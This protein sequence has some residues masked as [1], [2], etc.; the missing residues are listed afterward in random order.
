[1]ASHARI[2]YAPSLTS[3]ETRN[4]CCPGTC[5]QQLA[6]PLRSL[7]ISP[8]LG[9]GLPSAIGGLRILFLGEGNGQEVF[10][11][12]QAAGAAGEVFAVTPQQAR[13]DQWR[14]WQNEFSRSQGFDN[15]SLLYSGNQSL[16]QLPLAETSF[17]LIISLE[18]KQHSLL[19][20]APYIAR[21]LKS[22]GEWLRISARIPNRRPAG[23]CGPFALA[24]QLPGNH[25][26][27]SRW[28]KL[29]AEAARI[30]P[31]RLRYTG[32]IEECPNEL[33]FDQFRLVTGQFTSLPEDR[34]QALI[35]SRYRDYLVTEQKGA[36]GGLFAH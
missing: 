15:L 29:C 6:S 28:F 21:L 34:F 36:A 23:F 4:R 19:F 8:A 9:F 33:V 11:L 5:W 24:S 35:N 17:D 16:S 27:A 10:C 30:E 2:V 12:A 25:Y 18:P 32:G 22:G 1:M 20:D 31:T 26:R 7:D 14:H 3:E 13:L